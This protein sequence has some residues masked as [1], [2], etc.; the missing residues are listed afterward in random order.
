M[1]L[2]EM[3]DLRHRRSCEA[4]AAAMGPDCVPVVADLTAPGAADAVVH[5]IVAR[6]GGLD[7]LVSNAGAAVEGMILDLDEE[8]LAHVITVDGGTIEAALR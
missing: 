6:F 1:V 3:S 8:K 5:E 4:A 2:V 7:I